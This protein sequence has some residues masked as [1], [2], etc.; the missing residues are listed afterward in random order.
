ADRDRAW[1]TGRGVVD[2][3]DRKRN[4][5]RDR[6]DRGADLTEGIADRQENRDRE[7]EPLHAQCTTWNSIGF[8]FSISRKTTF[9]VS[10]C[11]KDTR[12]SV[13]ERGDT[14]SGNRLESRRISY[15]PGGRL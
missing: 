10:P 15:W 3:R 4:R 14:R 13:P 7:Q 1:R 8:A 11:G 9:I 2:V 5:R 6:H 12:T